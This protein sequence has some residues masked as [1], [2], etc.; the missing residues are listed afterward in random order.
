VTRLLHDGEDIAAEWSGAALAGV[1]AAVYAH[2][3]G[4]DEPLLRLSG[5]AASPAALAAH[6]A[7]DAIGSVDAVIFAGSAAN[8]ARQP[9]TT[10]ATA[11]DFDGATYPGSQLLDGRAPPDPA[12]RTR[13][14][15]ACRTRLRRIDGGVEVQSQMAH[16]VRPD[17]S[18]SPAAP[19][20]PCVAAQPPTGGAPSPLRL[21]LAGA[22]IY[23]L[24][25][26]LWAHARG[27]TLERSVIHDLTVGT[28]TALV[29]LLAPG[30]QAV[31]TGSRIA[32][33]GGGI[34]VLNGCEG[35][36]VLFLLVAAIV[37]H[38]A[39]WRRYWRDKLAGLALGTLAVFALNQVRVV[40]LFF[41]FRHD[42]E[43]FAQAHAWAAP[44]VLVVATLGL[45]ALWSERLAVRARRG[46]ASAA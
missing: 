13:R 14:S 19:D 28:A 25:Q 1:P 4:R 40:G 26:T 8:Q 45:F 27:S 33:P 43:L 10:L 42:R 3:F 39:P 17:S 30:A 46:A 6:Y 22:A 34:N 11:G 12:R 29:N 2:G 36:E 20:T 5:D 31:A 44:L 41:L 21:L 18:D 35:T 7:Q 37:V 38:P 9:G 24:L 16:A 23:I 15:S 32:A